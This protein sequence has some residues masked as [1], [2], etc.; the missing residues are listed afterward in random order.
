MPTNSKKRLLKLEEKSKSNKLEVW[1]NVITIKMNYTRL[2]TLKALICQLNIHIFVTCEE[3]FV[4]VP[5]QERREF[6]G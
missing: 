3:I 4:R 6:L 5:N 2:Y 1:L